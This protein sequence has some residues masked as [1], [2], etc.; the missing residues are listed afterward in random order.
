MQKHLKKNAGN[1]SNRGLL[2]PI[3]LIALLCL[4]IPFKAH[5][6]DV[7]STAVRA[8]QRVVSGIIL[9]ENNEPVIGASVVVKGT[10]IGTV[11]DLD[12]RFTLNVP[13][14]KKIITVSYMGYVNQDVNI[15]TNRSLTIRLKPDAKL[16]D[17]VVVVGYGTVMK[18]DLTGAI[19]SV[20]SEDIKAAPV[21]NAMEGLAGKVSGLDITRESGSA[22]SSP[23]ILLRGNRSLT[24]SSAPLFIIDGIAADGIDNLN[25]NDIESIEVLKDA[26]STAIYGAAGANGV[27][28]VTTKQGQ[29]GKV[30]VDANVY[31]GVNAFPSYPSTLSG[32]KWIDYLTE[33]YK[34]RYGELPE[35]N[36]VLFNT[37]LGTSTNAQELIANGEWVAWKDEI[38]H[39]GS[40]QNYKVSVRGG[41]EK[42]N[43]YMRVGYQ[44]ATGL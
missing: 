42:L 19:S 1:T 36:E 43:S 34:A 3:C 6:T 26:S 18:R 7:A 10:T 39:T 4:A 23:T 33:G 14:G 27:I 28:I 40:Q 2:I 22:G 37:V 20:K 5:A 11:S 29:A 17:E 16:L 38:L 9:D 8:V 32:Q 41:T 44:V 31:V 12:G 30:S 35:S 15:D 13:D 21:T 24:A 25:P